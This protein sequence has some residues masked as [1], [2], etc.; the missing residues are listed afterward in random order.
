MTIGLTDQ[1]TP[2]GT[3]PIVEDTDIKGGYHTVATIADRDAIPAADRKIGMVALVQND[4][5]RWILWA[6]LSTWGSD[7][8][9]GPTGP[10]GPTGP[11]GASG[12]SGVAGASG[13]TGPTGPTGLSGISGTIFLS[14][15]V[16]VV[17]SSWV[18]LGAVY[19]NVTAGTHVF[20]TMVDATSGRTVYVRLFNMT[21]AIEVD[22]TAMS[23]ASVVPIELSVTLTAGGTGFPAGQKVYL[24]EAKGDAGV[25]ISSAVSCKWAAL[26]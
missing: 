10:T 4:M 17:Q 26:S 2:L 23:S 20:R 11:S 9:S 24:L 19:F 22:G 18:T 16:S 1:I 6:D 21:D 8:S 15:N 13:A 14:N 7:A 12:A 5:T 25:S 3:F